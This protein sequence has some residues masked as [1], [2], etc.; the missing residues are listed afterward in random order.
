M[1]WPRPDKPEFYLR[2]VVEEV[3]SCSFDPAVAVLLLLFLLLYHRS[4]MSHGHEGAINSHWQTD[5]VQ[6][7]G[8]LS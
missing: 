1:T 4:F 6:G 2:A 7:S 3:L 8:W 5:G